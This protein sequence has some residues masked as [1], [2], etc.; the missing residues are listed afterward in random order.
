M[1]VC[2]RPAKLQG[3]WVL[4]FLLH[5][6]EASALLAT[7]TGALTLTGCAQLSRLPFVKP[8]GPTCVR[9]FASCWPACYWLVA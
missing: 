6:R 5:R 7:I 4:L 9:A 1:V 8:S 2:G 3:R